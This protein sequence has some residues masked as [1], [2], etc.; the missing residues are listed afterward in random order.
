VA[1]AGLDVPWLVRLAVDRP[2]VA[3]PWEAHEQLR[4]RHGLAAAQSIILDVSLGPMTIADVLRLDPG[5][6]AEYAYRAAKAACVRDPF[7]TKSAVISE[8]L[9]PT[10]RR[11]YGLVPAVATGLNL[12][13]AQTVVGALTVDALRLPDPYRPAGQVMAARA[14]AS[15]ISL[16]PMLLDTLV[17]S[18]GADPIKGPAIADVAVLAARRDGLLTARDLP[19]VAPL[20]APTADEL[21]ERLRPADNRYSTGDDLERATPRP[22]AGDAAWAIARYLG[23]LLRDGPF[24][25]RLGLL[26]QVDAFLL[27]SGWLASRLMSG[28]TDLGRLSWTIPQVDLGTGLT[29]AGILVA[30]HVLAL[31]LSSGSLPK[32]VAA[33]VA[34]PARL[35]SAYFVAAVMA[36]SQLLFDG[37]LGLST[38][39]ALVLFLHLPVVARELVSKS[40]PRRA[41]QRIWRDR[42]LD[43]RSAGRRSADVYRQQ[44]DVRQLLATS[45]RLRHEAVEPVTRRR[46]PVKAKRDGYVSHDARALKRMDDALGTS[47]ESP[48]RTGSAAPVFVMIE[49]AGTR[50]TEGDTLAVA[51]VDEPDLARRALRL[52]HEAVSEVRLRDVDR[53]AGAAG[54]L[55]GLL[56]LQLLDDEAGSEGTSAL[57]EAALEEFCA[58]ALAR[59]GGIEWP[60]GY[61]ARVLPFDPTGLVVRGAE[62]AWRGALDSD[63]ERR[64]EGMRQHV[65]R[66]ASQRR[67]NSFSSALDMFVAR[68][69]TVSSR[70]TPSQAHSCAALL[71]DLGGIAAE[72]AGHSSLFPIRD[73]M[74]DL[75]TRLHTMAP[76]PREAALVRQRFEELLGRAIIG[77]YFL[78]TDVE[79]GCQ[80]L[81]DLALAPS[82]AGRK[83]HVLLGVAK[84]GALA[85]D[86][87]RV[88]LAAII[89]IQLRQAKVDWRAVR[90]LAADE[91]TSLRLGALSSMAGGLFGPDVS[92]SIVGYADWAESLLASYP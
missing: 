65:L 1:H 62:A 19:A 22:G 85:L 70:A 24:P 30:L 36:I 71:A 74:Q 21:P 13:E 92:K 49:N 77:D 58:A 81:V 5:P 31:E 68:L 38:V 7:A 84:V 35:V 66:I 89:A 8:L 90:E 53:T 76:I 4:A 25:V 26:L 46:V 64:L 20:L 56:G 39:A 41:A 40:D 83:S 87:R 29:G 6:A 79:R 42:R 67:M 72:A 57:I 23:S 32:G 45:I 47:L 63:D 80:A 18:D 44:A 17:V 73:Q 9:A 51:L 52:G 69:S 14:L 59:L 55:V 27:A 82:L 48:Y 15:V 61:L 2:G 86:R 12:P 34:W 54:G 60:N 91:G 28:L 10:R 37:A 3:D 16:Y 75:I 88:A 11:A 50:V 78:E 43:F 33:R